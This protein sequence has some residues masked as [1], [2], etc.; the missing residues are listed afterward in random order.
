MYH[1]KQSK[2][3]LN[4]CSKNNQNWRNNILLKFCRTAFSSLELVLTLYITNSKL[5]GYKRR[6]N[7]YGSERPR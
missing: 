2:L 1:F 6:S 3:K 5:S 4:F 7:I